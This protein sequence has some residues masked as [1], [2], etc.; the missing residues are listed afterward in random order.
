MAAWVISILVVEV[1]F[2]INCIVHSKSPDIYICHVISTELNAMMS[3]AQLRIVCF[4][5]LRL[6]TL[7]CIQFFSYTEH[8]PWTARTNPVPLESALPSLNPPCL[9]ARTSLKLPCPPE[10]RSPSNCTEL[11]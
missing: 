3:T 1:V 8:A 7:F 5:S 6:H 10:S 2:N 9:S 11:L 4:C